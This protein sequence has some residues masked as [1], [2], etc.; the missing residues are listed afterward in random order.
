LVSPFHGIDQK[1]LETLWSS[2]LAHVRGNC[3][4]KFQAQCFFDTR[5]S[6]STSGFSAV[7]GTTKEIL[8]SV[9]ALDTSSLTQRVIEAAAGA[10]LKTLKFY[11]LFKE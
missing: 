1:V 8:S 3:I 11:F 10:F 5:K 7:P 6:K 9:P 4:Q 2:T